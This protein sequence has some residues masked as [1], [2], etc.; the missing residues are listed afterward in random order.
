MKLTILYAV[1][2]GFIS[3]LFSVIN[4]REKSSVTVSKIARS[5]PTPTF[6]ISSKKLSLVYLLGGEPGK[7][8]ISFSR[9]TRRIRHDKTGIFKLRFG[10]RTERSILSLKYIFNVLSN[11]LLK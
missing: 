11:S 8:R 1:S 3:E 6:S 2:E 4:P 10:G 5:T 9:S 7:S